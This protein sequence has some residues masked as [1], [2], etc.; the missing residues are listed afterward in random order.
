MPPRAS[1]G[2]LLPCARADLAALHT[3]YLS[4]LPGRWAQP[5]DTFKAVWRALGFS[6]IHQV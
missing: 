3:A 4:A 6:R 2:D 5:F 1:D